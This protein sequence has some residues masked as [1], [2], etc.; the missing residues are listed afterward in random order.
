MGQIMENV[1]ELKIELLPSDAQAIAMVT[2]F[3]ADYVRRV[4]NGRRSNKIIKSAAKKLIEDREKLK[5]SLLGKNAQ[6][7][8]K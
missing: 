7:S 4:L 2:G 1:T 5:E 8:G 3:T 6:P